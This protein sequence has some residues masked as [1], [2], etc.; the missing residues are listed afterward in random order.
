M[1]Y[2][3]NMRSRR[4]TLRPHAAAELMLAS[5]PLERNGCNLGQPRPAPAMPA[6]G[7]SAEELEMAAHHR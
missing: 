5:S 7:A 6:V 2:A 3:P 4:R 1:Q